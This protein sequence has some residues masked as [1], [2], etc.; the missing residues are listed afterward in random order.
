MTQAVQHYFAFYIYTSL[1]PLII[2]KKPTFTLITSFLT[3]HYLL[4]F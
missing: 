2:I 4:D 1:L 3:S